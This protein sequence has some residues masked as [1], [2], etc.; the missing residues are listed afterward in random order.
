MSDPDRQVWNALLSY[1]RRNHLPVWRQWFDELEPLGINSGAMLIRARSDVH[2]DYLRRDCLEAFN[3]ALC[4]VTSQLLAVRFLGPKDPGPVATTNGTPPAPTEAYSPSQAEL[5][6]R[7]DA[8]TINPDY[9]FENF[10]V[11]PNNRLAHAAAVAVSDNPGQAYNPLFIH[12]DVGLGKTHLLQAICLKIK[13]ARPE[14]VMHYI[15]CDGFINDFMHSVQSGRMGAFRHRFRDVDVLVID[16]I[17]FLAKRDRTQEE[18]FHTFNTLYQAR[19]QIVLSCD[20]PPEEIPDLEDRLVSRFNW[21]L[22]TKIDAPCYETRVAIVKSKAEI[23]H[24]PLPDDVAC[25]IAAQ[26][27]SN[28]RELEGAIIKIQ[29]LA[30]VEAREIDLD[31]ARAALGESPQRVGKRPSVDAIINVVTDFYSVKRTDL[32]GKRRHKSIS[33][34]R[35]VCMYLAR[36]ET[37]HSLEEIGAH[38]GGRDHTTVMHAVRTIES[39]AHDDVQ[40][41]SVVQ[42]LMRSLR[43]E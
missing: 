1:L 23:R 43:D 12:G 17:H 13:Q 41:A 40:F 36:K 42:S 28:I 7:P 11:G 2:R 30:S 5:A 16:D 19:K 38:F 39:K 27:D 10:V 14:S 32:L 33:L 37:S 35:Q 4:T 29:I 6:S 8:L 25:Y 21:G 18:F 9:G 26:I 31:L 24:M 22:V 15:S 34:P 3:D 20:A